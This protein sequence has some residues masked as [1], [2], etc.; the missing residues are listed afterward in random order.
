MER[1]IHVPP[2]TLPEGGLALPSP[3]PQAGALRAEAQ[4]LLAIADQVLAAIQPV[5]A[6]S[7][8]QQNRQRGG[9]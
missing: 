5:D 2:P 9:E 1:E 3:S 8:L 7:Y 4:A 6:E